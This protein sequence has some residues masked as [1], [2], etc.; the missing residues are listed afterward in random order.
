MLFPSVI[1]KVA[2]EYNDAWVLFEINATEQVPHIMYYELEYENILFV[3]RGP[4]GQV[5]SAGFAKQALQLGINTDKK[6]KRIGCN[7]IKAIV[8]EGKLEI[9]D[10]DVISELST[11]IQVKDSYAADDGYHDDLAMALVIFGWMTT[12]AYFKD[13]VDIDLRTSIYQSR[14]EAIEQEQMPIG[15]F[16][17][18]TETPADEVFVF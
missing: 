11:F 14:I 5:I 9:H 17:D 12:Q 6:T 18:G 7:N 16:T 2:K 8:E 1:E 13:L 10:A 15:W 3:T 4:K